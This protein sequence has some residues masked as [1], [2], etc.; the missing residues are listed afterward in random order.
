MKQT[1]QN[2]LEQEVKLDRTIGNLFLEYLEDHNKPTDKKSFELFIEQAQPVIDGSFIL[3]EKRS[4]MAR[5][6]D[7]LKMVVKPSQEVTFQPVMAGG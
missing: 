2:E 3:N 6:V 5:V 1:F 4:G 7:V